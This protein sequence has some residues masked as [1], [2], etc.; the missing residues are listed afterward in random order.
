MDLCQCH[1][2]HCNKLNRH[3]QLSF[4]VSA[5]RISSSQLLLNYFVP[6]FAYIQV[7]SSPASSFHKVSLLSA[8]AISCNKNF[9]GTQLISLCFISLYRIVAT[10]LFR[11]PLLY[12]GLS[13]KPLANPGQAR[14]LDRICVFV[15][16]PVVYASFR[17]CSRQPRV[18][19]IIL[20]IRNLKG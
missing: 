19:Y 1:Q 14:T 17:P 7:I 12:P 10:C 8:G 6:T 3:R 11:F 16:N 9:G 13:S 18:Y 5:P 4:S 20:R 15:P 2:E